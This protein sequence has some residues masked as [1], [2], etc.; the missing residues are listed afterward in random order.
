MNRS[1]DRDAK[2]REI[3]PRWEPILRFFRIQDP[4]KWIF[5]SM[6]VGAL[7][8]MFS[9][10]FFYALE[11]GRYR[12]FNELAGIPLGVRTSESLFPVVAGAE[13]NRILFFVLPIIGGL[14]SGILVYW[15][16]PEAEGHGMD[17]LIDSFHNK[18]GYIKTRVPFV[19]A[20]AT[21]FTLSSGG[22]AGREGPVAQIG[23]GLGS[24]MA[25]RL[26]FSVRDTRKLVLAGTAGGL[27]SIFRSPLGGAITAIEVLYR[28]DFESEALIPCIIS[29]VTGFAIFSMVFGHTKILEV[30]PYFWRNPRELPFFALLG[31]I[32][33][34]AGIVYIRVFYWMRNR[35]FRPM[36]IPRVVKP[37]IGG[38]GVGCVGLLL[39]EV[40]GAGWG[41]LQ[42][43][44]NGDLGIQLMFLI[45][46]GKIL[47]TSFTIGS[48]G[49]GGVFGPSLFIGGMLGGAV[50][51]ICHRFFPEIVTTPEVFVLVGMCAFFASVANAP[52]GALLMTTEMT[53]SYYGLVTPLLL[54]SVIAL[55]FTRRWSI[56]E[57][58]VPDRFSSPAHIGDLT[59]NV[60]EEMR[61]GEVFE[62]EE[63]IVPVQNSMAFPDFRK[64]IT[65]TE[66]DYFPVYDGERLS[67]IVSLKTVR[68]V[69]FEHELDSILVVKDVAL[70]IVTVNPEENLYSALA[71]FLRSGYTQ[72]PVV[73]SNLP[74]R[75][76]GYLHHEDLMSAYHKEILR[77]KTDT[78]SRVP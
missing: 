70:P 47:A 8:G 17:A 12:C 32:C 48:G 18:M 36:K 5:Y 40:Y 31:L 75:V 3:K 66:I 9:C 61:V 60:L 69:L 39:P 67:G 28:E 55:L 58:Q 6:G 2:G 73:D 14:L 35:L 59:I 22:S 53:G 33:I 77:R 62:P 1:R 71:K 11:Y 37:M 54:V 41:Q 45:V 24:W 65:D 76:L 44:L 19:K 20:A 25:R 49:S 50:G 16:A 72:I 26:R 56:Y 64:M 74:D 34:P 68:P 51:G 15:L 27:G 7:T 30:P 63:P 4:V 52:I 57:K 78:H 43:A 38:L 21:I 46:G 23:G 13:P 42:R 10:L 29:S